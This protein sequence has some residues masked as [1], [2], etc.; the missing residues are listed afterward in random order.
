[1]LNLLALVLNT[2]IIEAK[3]WSRVH[4]AENFLRYHRLKSL[5]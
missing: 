1:M 4:A 3:S 5:L 2:G